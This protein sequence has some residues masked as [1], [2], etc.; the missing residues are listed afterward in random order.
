VTAPATPEQTVDRVDTAA[1]AYV[2]GYPLVVMHRTRALHSSRTPL[3][4]L[5]HSDD[6]ATPKSRTVVAPNND[7]LY[8][9]GWFDLSAGDLVIDVPAMDSA[10]RYWSVMLLDAY[11]EVAYACR[12]LHG[13]EGATVRVTLDPET[14]PSRTGGGVITMA[15]PTI[16]VLVRVLT[17]G[18]HDIDLAR[19]LQRSIA[20]SA[21]HGHPQ[22]TVERGG[23]P[24]LVHEAGAAYFT[25]LAA[26]L[27]VDPP[28]AWHPQAS[29]AVTALLR[30]AAAGSIPDDVLAAGVEVGEARLRAFGLGNDAFANGWGTR[31]KGSDFG[32]DVL[33]RAT[34][35]KLVLAG[36][37]PVENRSYV[38]QTDAD[39][40][41]LDGSRPLLLTFPAG[42]EPPC[43]GFWS[44]TVYGPDMFLVANEIDRWSLGDRTPGLPRGDDGSLAITIGGPRPADT[45]SWL[46]AP[47]GPYRLGLRVYEGAPEIVDAAWFPP[48]LVPAG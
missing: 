38:A 39:G 27:L 47:A 22:G 16:W 5:H 14:P 28:G 13:T 15:T 43:T 4:T 20:V 48:A 17:E 1:D 9:S 30:D 18:P 19:S 45:S 23:R 32:D 40:A 3:G 41:P 2:W 34:C 36:H 7:T 29:D 26:A 31:V 10:D 42:G 37:H 46:P 6:L 33:L 11:T 44:L 21:P 25:E 24:N 8:S 12:R 35:A